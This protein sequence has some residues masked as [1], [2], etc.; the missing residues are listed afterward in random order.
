MRIFLTGGTGYLGSAISARLVAAGHTVHGLAR[1]DR[2]ATALAAAGVAPVQGD[3]ADIDVLRRAAR[4]AD[5]VVHAGFSHDDWSRMDAAFAQDERAVAAMLDALAGTEKPFVYT[6]G[7]GVLADTGLQEAAEDAPLSSDPGVARRIAVERQV[8]AAAVRGV[9][10]RPGLVYGRGGSGVLHLLI[11]LARSAGVGRTVGEGA[12]AWS[13]VHVDDVAQAYAL[14]LEKAP[15]GQVFH[16]AAGEPVAMHALA[17]AIGRALGQSGA[18]EPWPLDEARGQLGLLADG[19]ASNKRNSAANA[20]RVL[21]WQPEGMTL[22][23]ELARGSYGA[24][25]AGEAA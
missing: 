5:G 10:M 6:S 20:S 11:G 21:G 19:L 15:A 4:D 12:N 3:L 9:V 16:L 14:A 25:R 17:S 24:A 8:L 18:V 1:S 13:A 23:E 7:S 22:F 2:A